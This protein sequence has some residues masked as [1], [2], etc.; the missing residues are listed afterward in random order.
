[1]VTAYFEDSAFDKLSGTEI[2]KP[3]PFKIYLILVPPK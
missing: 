2:L 1:M 3:S